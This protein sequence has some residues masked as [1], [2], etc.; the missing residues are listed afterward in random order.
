[1][2]Q[3]VTNRSFFT[4]Y[5]R[6]SLEYSHLFLIFCSKYKTITNM[7]TKSILTVL[8][9]ITSAHFLNAQITTAT[10]GRLVA[11]MPTNNETSALIQANYIGTTAT[12]FP[13]VEGNNSI[14][15]YSGFGLRGVG[16]FIGTIGEVSP[17]GNEVYYGVVGTLTHQSQDAC[18]NT[19]NSYGVLGQ[20]YNSNANFGVYGDVYD[21]VYNYG[22]Y[23]SA[24]VE[25]NICE[26]EGIPQTGYAGYFNGN[27][28]YTGDLIGPSDRQF[29]TDEKPLRNSLDKLMDLKPKT[30]EYKINEYKGRMNFPKGVQMGFIAQELQKVIPEAVVKSTHVYASGNA[31]DKTRELE[32]ID[33]LGINYMML[34]PI[35]TSAIQE[36]QAQI[37]QKDT[38]IADLHAQL[39]AQ[40]SEI[41]QIKVA[42]RA[43]GANMP[44]GP[45]A[46]SLSQN[47]PN[48]FSGQTLIPYT[49]ADGVTNAQL[50]VYE[51]ESGKE[52]QRFSLAPGSGQVVFKKG[53]EVLGALAYALY[54]D[55]KLAATQK[56]IAK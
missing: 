13:A 32:H 24:P 3:F 33:Y 53:K 14:N 11:D 28:A 10:P 22:V 16:G 31:K 46:S 43:L 15:D 21:G 18:A 37:N 25:G 52:V 30:Y 2:R 5:N 49:V 47:M 54:V 40:Q 19:A 29:K 42:L 17:S 20:S 55:G 27:L 23:G 1:L 45:S 6:T 34:L 9:I 38:E 44:K 41:D 50:V 4:S 12:D 35:L 39:A 8:A 26:A 7:K 51:L 36:Q 56:M 48:P